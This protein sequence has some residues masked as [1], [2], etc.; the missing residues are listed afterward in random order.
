MKTLHMVLD[1]HEVGQLVQDDHGATRVT[2]RPTR[3][4]PRVSLAFPA[5]DT[6]V[7]PLLTRTYLAGLLPDNEDV[8]EAIARRFKVSPESQFALMGVI[9]AD[10]PGA[11]QFLTDQ[12]LEEPATE[13][14]KPISD[15]EI[16][17]RLRNFRAGQA[18]WGAPGEHWS[19]G[20]AQAKM[21]LR[22]EGDAWLQAEGTAATSHIIKPGIARL[23][24]QALIEHVSLRALGH[25]GL[26]VAESRFSYFEDQP[27]IIVKRFDR[28]WDDAGVLR[29]VHQ[30]DLCQ[31]TST[32]PA[33]KY[34]VKAEDAIKVLR[35]GG[36][37]EEII[38]EFV[39][40]V[41]ANWVLAAPDAHGKNY[42]VVLGPAGVAA[43]TPL[44]DVSTG[45][46]YPDAEKVAMGLG[47]EKVIRKITGRH[48]LEFAST[49]GV[50]G[51]QVL[52]A[53]SSMTKIMP[54][55]F[56][57]AIVDAR[58]EA[59]MADEDRNWLNETVDRVAA[60]CEHVLTVL[61]LTT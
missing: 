16:A 53:A 23:K 3:G 54:Y 46:G 49:V 58:Q 37:S 13:A 8:R 51:E 31:S 61:K 12:Q 24:S 27:A 11:I 32:L 45:L 18:D 39:R 28:L 25:L 59:E 43:L 26:R 17:Q 50:D 44:Y 4:L 29:R 60:H 34:D 9:G 15:A 10:C 30:E 5:S 41:I 19:L 22:L 36:A 1:G 38:L 57:A 40:A 42:S 33:K 52:A 47:G 21:A 2:A 7:K 6:P 48:L 55:A 35:G 20:G 14:L 56:L